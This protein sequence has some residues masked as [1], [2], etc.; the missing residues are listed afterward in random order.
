MGQK[1]AAINGSV[2]IVL[3]GLKLHIFFWDDMILSIIC[4]ER[5]YLTWTLTVQAAGFRVPDGYISGFNTSYTDI[6][7]LA[8]PLTANEVCNIIKSNIHFFH[9]KTCG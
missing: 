8:V 5:P 3:G 4:K 9:K 2:T 7:L 6:L 1:L